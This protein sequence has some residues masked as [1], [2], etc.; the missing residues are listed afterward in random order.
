MLQDPAV[1]ERTRHEIQISSQVFGAYFSQVFR[2]S[3]RTDAG[4]YIY[5]GRKTRRSAM[6]KA[7]YDRII[8]KDGPHVRNQINVR[9]MQSIHDY[10]SDFI[11]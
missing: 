7:E 11:F 1:D 9:F 5:Q 2:S 6:V 10:S 4:D 8:K 3:A